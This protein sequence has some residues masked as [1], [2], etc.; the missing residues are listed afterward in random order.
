MPHDRTSRSYLQVCADRSIYLSFTDYLSSEQTSF[1]GESTNS[2]RVK[3]W[4]SVLG[5][6]GESA[7][8]PVMSLVVYAPVESLDQ[9]PEPI[10]TMVT[11]WVKE[12]SDPNGFHKGKYQVIL[13]TIS[14]Q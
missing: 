10:K 2:N 9:L 14:Q 7:N 8:E 4:L 12:Y 5:T 1:A 3:S 6:P 11:N 13:S